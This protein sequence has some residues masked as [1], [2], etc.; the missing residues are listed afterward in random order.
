MTIWNFIDLMKNVEDL[1]GNLLF[2]IKYQSYNGKCHRLKY[3]IWIDKYEVYNV[4]CIV[5][6]EI[7]SFQWEMCRA[8]EE[9]KLFYFKCHRVNE[10]CLGFYGIINDLKVSIFFF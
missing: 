3:W 4:K 8:Y 1:M 7:S 9:C 5:F 2:L 10:K 6:C